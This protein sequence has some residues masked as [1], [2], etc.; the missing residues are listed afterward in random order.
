MIDKNILDKLLEISVG[1]VYSC[2]KCNYLLAFTETAIYFVP[3]SE[4]MSGLDN[5]IN[6]PEKILTCDE[7]IIKSI[8][9][10]I[11]I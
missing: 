1:M 11:I 9:E 4:H 7:C 5:I 10:W 6:I 8:I 2:E 3:P